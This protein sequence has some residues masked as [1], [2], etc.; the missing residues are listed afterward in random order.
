M[1]DLYYGD[2]G[3]GARLFVAR[4]I[5]T[6]P[7]I[8]S[9]AAGTGGPLLWNPPG[10]GVLARL[11]A[12]SYAVTVASTVAGAIGLTGGAGQTAA[13]GSTTVIDTSGNLF[14]GGR[15]PTISA[16]RIGTP[17]SAGSFFWPLG[18]VSTSALTALGDGFNLI[19]LK[20]QIVIPPGGWL[21]FA[22]SA[23]LTTAVIQAALAWEE[24]PIPG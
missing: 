15:P 5:V 21:S 23:T 24:V 11:V 1:D 12:A 14:L 22:G 10:S 3:L 17:S 16:F 8:F 4:A 20:R 2:A 18:F 7:V 19:D 13:P 9:T 6:A